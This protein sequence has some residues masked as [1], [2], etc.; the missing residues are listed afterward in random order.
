MKKRNCIT[1]LLLVLTGA[2]NLVYAAGQSDFYGVWVKKGDSKSF[3]EINKGAIIKINAYSTG[4][5]KTK[6][7][8][9]KWEKG[10]GSDKGFKQFDIIYTLNNN[11]KDTFYA[12]VDAVL[13]LASIAISQTW[14]VCVA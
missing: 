1:L 14:L 4:V 12:S 8:I 10:K 11:E 6:Y 3:Y 2:Y 5:E 13:S 7:N 9:V